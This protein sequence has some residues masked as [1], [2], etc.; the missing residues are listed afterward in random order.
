MMKFLNCIEMISINDF[1]LQQFKKSSA[2]VISLKVSFSTTKKRTILGQCPKTGLQLI[3]IIITAASVINCTLHSILHENG[4][5]LPNNDFNYKVECIK[6][7]LFFS[8]VVVKIHCIM[9]V[10]KCENIHSNSYTS[11]CSLILEYK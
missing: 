2:T 6:P 8:F 7:I 5:Q 3:I 1:F 9:R 10:C 4:P 11:T